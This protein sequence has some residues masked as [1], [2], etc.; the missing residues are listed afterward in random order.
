MVGIL[1]PAVPRNAKCSNL[2]QL[3]ASPNSRS[4]PVIL[5][6][7]TPPKKNFSKG[8]P[9]AL[10]G[11][12]SYQLAEEYTTRAVANRIYKIVF[13]RNFSGGLR[14]FGRK[15]DEN[16]EATSKQQNIIQM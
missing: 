13:G 14:A 4:E 10:L 8:V 16:A 11:G 6:G 15:E 7:R 1:K 5:R 9:F 12:R 2:H 3:A